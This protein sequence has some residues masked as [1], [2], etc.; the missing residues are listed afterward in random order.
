LVLLALSFPEK[1]YRFQTLGTIGKLRSP[2]GTVHPA[3]AGPADWSIRMQPLPELRA[4]PGLTLGD[5]LTVDRG[6]QHTRQGS[7]VDAA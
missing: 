7:G 1:T 5:Q 4:L 3:L 6:E 2:E